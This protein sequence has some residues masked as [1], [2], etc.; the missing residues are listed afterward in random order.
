MR[1]SP[2][3]S[4]SCSGMELTASPYQ[5]ESSFSMTT[6]NQP[7]NS[8]E[9]AAYWLTLLDQGFLTD[10]DREK[11]KKWLSEPVNRMAF[12]EYRAL[13]SVIQDLPRQ[14]WKLLSRPTRRVKLAPGCRLTAIA[15]F[16]LPEALFKR[17]V[18]PTI[19]DMQDEYIDALAASDLWHARWI[20]ARGHLLVIPGCVYAFL[21]GKLHPLFGPRK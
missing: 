13:V 21:A 5:L 4:P 11:F 3:G 7:D 15:R 1:F 20:V 18:W 19:A 16:L 2:Q 17:Y 14:K 6:K 8:R 12:N 10:S 9:Q